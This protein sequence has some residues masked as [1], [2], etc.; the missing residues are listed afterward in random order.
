MRVQA[1]APDLLPA[2]LGFRLAVRGIRQMRVPAPAP[3]SLLAQKEPLKLIRSSFKHR[4][5]IVVGSFCAWLWRKKLLPYAGISRQVK[6]SGLTFF[7]FF[8]SLANF[9]L[10]IFS[11]LLSNQ[12]IFPLK[13]KAV[14]PYFLRR[15]PLFHKF[16]L[17]LLFLNLD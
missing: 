3:D 8:S 13:G 7:N 4:V 1:S 16:R 17:V 2:P 5:C 12:Y 15:N 11:F 10:I 14:F 9:G 6:R